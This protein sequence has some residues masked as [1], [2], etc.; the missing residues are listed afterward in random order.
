M[1]VISGGRTI[2]YDIHGKGRRP[3]L[4]LPALGASSVMWKPQV[5]VFSGYMLVTCETGGHFAVGGPQHTTIGEYA[6]D[7]TAVMD[8]VGLQ[9][10]CVVGLSMGGMVAQELAL[11]DPERVIA[12]VLVST[13]STYPEANRDILRQRAA[14]VEAQ[15]MAAVLDSILA[16]WLTEEYRRACPESEEVVRRDLLG[17][18]ARAYAGAARVVAEIDTTERLSQIGV[19]T[20]IVE[21]AQDISLP[22]SASATLE[23]SIPGARRVVI[24]DAAHLCNLE[25]S[26]G[27]NVVLGDFLDEV[28]R[29]ARGEDLAML[30]PW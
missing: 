28:S 19:P 13:T 2:R 21:G 26:V 8:A 5:D 15:G 23:R 4:L 11:A 14:A 22:E 7:A 29:S 20:L 3:V 27:F 1:Q 30:S 10:A 18:D 17:A 6:R 16:R 24:D 9:G 12:L 25:R